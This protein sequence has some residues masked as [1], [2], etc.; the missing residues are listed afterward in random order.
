MQAHTVK[1]SER[2]NLIGN[3]C[4]DLVSS[5]HPDYLTI[6]Q[7]FNSVAVARFV[8]ILMTQI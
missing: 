4:T 8:M 1:H 5:I 6:T 7:R 2:D 3:I